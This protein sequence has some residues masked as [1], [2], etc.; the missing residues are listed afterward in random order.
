MFQSNKQYPKKPTRRKNTILWSRFI[1]RNNAF[2]F[3]LYNHSVP[4]TTRVVTQLRAA[5]IAAATRAYTLAGKYRVMNGQS[6]HQQPKDGR[7]DDDS[8]LTEFLASL[9]DYTPTVKII[10]YI[11]DYNSNFVFIRQ[12]ITLM[13]RY[14]MNW[15]S[16]TWQ[17]V[18]SSAPISDCRYTVPCLCTLP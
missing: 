7:H 13:Y 12:I 8:A 9:M 3:S 11:S 16:I 6:S 4:A 5:F 17:K 15:W 1:W 10:I 2:L 14:L 18:D